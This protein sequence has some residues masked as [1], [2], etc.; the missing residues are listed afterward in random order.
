MGLNLPALTLR[1]FWTMIAHYHGQT[2]NASE[3][4]RSLGVSDLT[5]RRYRLAENVEVCPLIE[6]RTDRPTRPT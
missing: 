4:G 6:A 5:T 2:W 3:I 1:R